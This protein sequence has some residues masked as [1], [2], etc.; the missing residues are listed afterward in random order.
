MRA[1]GGSS[2]LFS[3]FL[4]ISED[5]SRSLRVSRDS[6]EVLLSVLRGPLGCP[7]DLAVLCLYPRQVGGGTSLQ[8][9]QGT[10]SE[11]Q[12]NPKGLPGTFRDLIP[13]TSRETPTDLQGPS[14]TPVQTLQKTSRNLQGKPKGLQGNLRDPTP[15]PP[16]A[17]KEI[18]RDFQGPS[19]IPVWGL[20]KKP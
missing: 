14:G 20:Q 5:S 16:G 19:G 4:K 9:P 6:R 3:R 15:G 1:P 11:L 8:G 18:P 12:G 17:S 7:G 13:G 2:L 10:S